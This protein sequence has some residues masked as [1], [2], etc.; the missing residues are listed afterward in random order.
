MGSSKV[1]QAAFSYTAQHGT[2]PWEHCVSEPWA[3]LGRSVSHSMGR[4]MGCSVGK[5][6]E[7]L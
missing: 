3:A 5:G 6:K 7:S 4:S 2:D 1:G